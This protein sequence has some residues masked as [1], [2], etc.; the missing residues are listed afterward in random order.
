MSSHLWSAERLSISVVSANVL[1]IVTFWQAI[2]R[3]QRTRPTRCWSQVHVM[4]QYWPVMLV[5][6]SFYPNFKEGA[7]TSYR[8]TPRTKRRL[9]VDRPSALLNELMWKM[10]ETHFVMRSACRYVLATIWL[11]IR[12]SVILSLRYSGFDYISGQYIML[13]AF[14]DPWHPC[15]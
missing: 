12:V 5:A 4:R 3:K 14:C 1:S 10:F 13:N 7:E 6:S 8:D 15:F 9:L 2:T 11:P